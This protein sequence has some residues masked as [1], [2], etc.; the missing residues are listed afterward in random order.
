MNIVTHSRGL[1]VVQLQPVPAILAVTG[2]NEKNFMNATM[3]V[4]KV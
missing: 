4:V 1:K 2:T 3:S